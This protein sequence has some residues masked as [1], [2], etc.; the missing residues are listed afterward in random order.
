MKCGGGRGGRG[1]QQKCDGNGV[2]GGGKQC[3][4]VV[5]TSTT[6]D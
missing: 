1:K 2:G 5:Y 4:G 3:V 6:Y